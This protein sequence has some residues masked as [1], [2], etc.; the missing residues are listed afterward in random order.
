MNLQEIGIDGANWIRLAQ[1]SVQW[2]AFVS[3]VMNLD[4]GDVN[5]E[6][7]TTELLHVLCLYPGINSLCV[8]N[9]C[10]GQI[11]SDFQKKMEV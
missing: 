5:S 9:C 3:M 8:T 7:E 6:E 4:A 1:D 2:R 10:L 11:V